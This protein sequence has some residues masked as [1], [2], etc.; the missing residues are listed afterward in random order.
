MDVKNVFMILVNDRVGLIIRFGQIKGL[1]FWLL[2]LSQMGR[3]LA[4]LG[5]TKNT[6][7]TARIWH[8]YRIISCT[9]SKLDLDIINWL[10]C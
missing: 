4:L 7:T 1:L 2:T 5:K 10:I 6:N 9:G 8:D 3:R